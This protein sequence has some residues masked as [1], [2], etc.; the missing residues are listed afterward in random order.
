MTASEIDQA[1]PVRFNNDPDPD[2]PG[3]NR[4]ELHDDRRFNGQVMGK[5]LVRLEDGGKVR[6]RMF[7][8]LRHTNLLDILHGGTVLAL[9]DIAIFSGGHTLGLEG[10]PGSVTL[11]LTTQFIGA[12]R[13]GVPLDAVAEVLRE[14]K[15][16]VFVRGVVE[17]EG[18]LVA[19]Y[20]A[21]IRKA[22][23]QS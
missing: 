6:T 17:Q 23:R 21:T 3:W 12:G 2:H 19:A 9:I 14:T 16:L 18:E 15:R 11:D 13:P 22:R 1:A 8:E 20:S 10:M 4:W 5:M 7:P